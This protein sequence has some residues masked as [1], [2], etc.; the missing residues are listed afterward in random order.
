MLPDAALALTDAA[1]HDHCPFRGIERGLTVATLLP[2]LVT[3]LTVLLLVG[4][5]ML[6][7]YM[8]GKH[9][10]QAPATTGHPQFERAF[11]VQ[12][13]TQETALAFLPALW[14]A[15]LYMSALIAGLLGL[16][17]VGARIWYAWAYVRDPASRG[18]A[19]GTSMVALIGL[20]L[21]ALTGLGRAA[22]LAGGA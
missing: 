22:L 14:V 12:M 19:F 1:A 13:N 11:R 21:L 10:I 2:P 6:V 20:V 4:T 18:P 9:A 3:I 17:W 16:L 5:A 7:G 15:A 8:R